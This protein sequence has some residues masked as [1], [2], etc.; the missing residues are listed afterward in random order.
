M[1]NTRRFGAALLFAVLA[2]G[3]AG[4]AG[5]VENIT[6]FEQAMLPPHCQNQRIFHYCGAMVHLF[7]AERAGAN[8]RTKRASAL[9]AVNSMQYSIRNMEKEG[10]RY[11]WLLPEAYTNLG[12]AHYLADSA[13]DAIAA[14]QKA[15]EI[16][17]DHEPGYY[18]LI[19][20]YSKL[21]KR[22]EA[23]KV[24]AAGVGHI[25]GSRRLQTKYV[26][27][28]GKLPLPAPQQAKEA[29]PIEVAQPAGSGEIPKHDEITGDAATSQNSVPDELGAPSPPTADGG[30]EAA[31]PKKKPSCRFCP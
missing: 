9:H 27:L 8:S 24:A 11:R 12:K 21:G 15:L 14:V 10:T 1:S 2:G 25:P 17:P 30:S 23:R 6:S 3:H 22:D 19:E 31:P 16:R 28:G 20:I 29:S 26:D 13:G 18:V 5:A 7:R 4:I